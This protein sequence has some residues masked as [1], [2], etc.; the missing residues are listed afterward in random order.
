VKPDPKTV[1]WSKRFQPPQRKMVQSETAPKKPVPS[2]PL[3]DYEI[4]SGTKETVG[5]VVKHKDLGQ[6][7]IIAVASSY[8]IVDFGKAGRF[9]IELPPY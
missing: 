1:E 9:K 2:K 7:K 4:T 6:G 3:T 8:A 5:S